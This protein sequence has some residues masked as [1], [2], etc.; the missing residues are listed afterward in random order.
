MSDP[1]PFSF[2]PDWSNPITERLSW[3]TTVMQSRSGAEQRYAVRLSPRRQIDFPLQLIGQERSYFDVILGRNGGGLWNVPIPHEEILIGGVSV[4]Q[5]TL[6]F[7]PAYREIGVGTKLLLRQEWD[8]SEIVTV[9]AV[10]S[11]SVTITPAVLSY[12]AATVTPTFLGVISENVSVSRLTA[13]VYQMTVRFTSQEPAIWPPAGVSSS[14][15]ERWTIGP[16]DFLALTHPP[17]AINSLDYTYERMWSAIDGDAALPLYVDK[18]ARQFTTQKYEF[19][20]VG[21]Q[22][23]SNFRNLLYGLQGR[24]KPIW[25]PTFNDDMAPGYSYPNPLGLSWLSVPGR[26][27]WLKFMRDGTIQ[28]G[29]LSVDFSGYNGTPPEVFDA[30]STVFQESFVNVKR[31][32]V[33]DIEIQHYGGIDG[34]ATC[35]VIF[36]D[37]PDLRVTAGYGGQAYPDA[38]YHRVGGDVTPTN[39]IAADSVTIANLIAEQTVT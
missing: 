23:K 29:Y 14:P 16:A 8:L 12:Q 25:V 5:D 22:E 27:N 38:V 34:V 15:P 3:L 19:F 32:D 30:S 1:I 4:G 31:L 35:S 11:A 20:L 39:D 2:K 28:T 10:D 9:T 33:D 37:A 13:R 21:P 36:R 7:D 18:A 6:F 26:E 24:L 17:N